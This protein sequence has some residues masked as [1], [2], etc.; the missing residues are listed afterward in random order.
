M[1]FNGR[2]HVNL[3]NTQVQSLEPLNRLSAL[4]TALPSACDAWQ[5]RLTATWWKGW[6]TNG[7]TQWRLSDGALHRRGEGGKAGDPC[8]AKGVA[9]AD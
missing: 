9:A 6:R 7:R 8:A 1:A 3:A 2:P 5:A 4:Q